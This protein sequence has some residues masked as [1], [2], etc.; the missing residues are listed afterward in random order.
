MIQVSLTEH[1][2]KR[3]IELLKKSRGQH[4]KILANYLEQ[5]LK[6]MAELDLDEIPF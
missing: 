2:L 6:P 1:N 3:I 5:R 4:D